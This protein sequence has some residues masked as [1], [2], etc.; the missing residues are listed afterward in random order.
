MNNHIIIITLFILNPLLFGCSGYTKT[1]TGLEYKTIQKGNGKKPKE[2]DYI[3]LKVT[4]LVH[5]NIMY[6]NTHD[7]LPTVYQYKTETLKKDGSIQEIILLLEEQKKIEAKIEAKKLLR[8]SWI[9]FQKKFN[10]QEETIIKVTLQAEKIL[11]PKEYNTWKEQKIQQ[12][13]K[14]KQKKMNTQKQNDIK[15][16][17]TYIQNNNLQAES[18]ASG[19]RYI[20]TQKGNEKFPKP[21]QKVKVHYTG[22]TLEGNFF[23]SSLAHIAKENQVYNAQRKYSPITFTLGAKQVI[24][25]WDE[26]IALF[27]VGTKAKV[28]IP[29]YLA[30]G[31]QAVGSVIKA[32][33]IL[34]F[35]IELVDIVN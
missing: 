12:I 15:K 22:K 4:Y 16:I 20:I 17:D 2:E 11:S 5:K 31:D 10:L 1:P 25:G 32:N 9:H 28:F 24:A 21:G 14:E 35:D 34:V 30:Y 27:S 33:S 13:Q 7:H 23:D 29:S 6:D 18:T 26:A 8:E 3:I 19:L